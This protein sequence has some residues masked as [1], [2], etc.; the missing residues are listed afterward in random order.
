MQA[1]GLAGAE[2]LNG[3]SEGTAKAGR[4]VLSLLPAGVLIHQ[5]YASQGRAN[6]KCRGQRAPE[7]PD[8]QTPLMFKLHRESRVENQQK[9]SH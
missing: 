9:R 8:S 6:G 1:G 3:G 7:K 5:D 4:A 2:E